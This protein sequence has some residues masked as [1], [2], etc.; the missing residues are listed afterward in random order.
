MS[1]LYPLLLLLI[2]TACQAGPYPPGSPYY[3]IPTGSQVIIKQPLTIPANTAT[4]Y[5]Q[6]GH[7]VSPAE[8]DQYNPHCWLSS[9]KVLDIPQTIQPGSFVV[10][11]VKDYEELV[12]QNT[13]LIPASSYARNRF[14]DGSGPT[15]AEYKTELTIHSDSQPDI[16]KLVCNHWEDPNGRYLT[17]DQIH[18]ALGQYVEIILKS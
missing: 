1:R 4:V 14:T 2:L 18:T 7:P 13:G 3:T 12:Y 8:I 6:N 11:G 16:R 9:W 5:L 10:I 17:T 15:A